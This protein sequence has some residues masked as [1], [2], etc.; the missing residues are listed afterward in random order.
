MLKIRNA[1]LTDWSVWSKCDP[2]LTIE[3][4]RSKVAARKAFVFYDGHKLVGVFRYNMFW[5]HIPFVTLL[6]LCEDERDK[7]YG[8]EIMERW[9]VMMRSRG[10][11]QLMVS[12]PVNET[13]QHFFR[14]LGYRDCGCLLL[15]EPGREGESQM[16]LFL[17][18]SI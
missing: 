17:Q 14:Q 3:Q 11:T 10:Y 8:H 16:E 1:E 13:A 7:G 18:K 4:F 9:E 15:E 6:Y 2:H 12:T 5:D